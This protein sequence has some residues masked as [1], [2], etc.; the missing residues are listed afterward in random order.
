[1]AIK[2]APEEFLVEETLTAEAAAEIRPSGGRFAL[3]RLTKTGWTTPEAVYAVARALGIKPAALA[4]GGLKDKHARTLQHLSLDTAGLPGPAPESLAG[5]NWAALRLGTVRR[6]MSADSV[7]GNRFRIVIRKLSAEACARMDAAT[8]DFALPGR[9]TGLRVVNYFG[10]QRF[11]SA[12]HGQGFAA[13]HL[14]RDEWEAG[15]R[16]ILTAVARKDDR[17]LKEAK[18]AIEAGWGDWK[19]VLAA[20]PP[21]GPL[22]GPVERLARGGSYAVAFQGLPYIDQQMHVE[23]F[24]SFLWNE[25]A[26]RTVEAGCPGPLRVAEMRYGR[27]VHPPAASVTGELASLCLPLLCPE[28][29]LE[30]PWKIP[31]EQVLAAEQIG[32]KRLRLPGLRR[33]WFGGTPRRLFLETEECDLGAPSPDEHAPGRLRRTLTLWLPRAAYATVVLQALGAPGEE[34]G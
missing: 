23:A 9:P 24:Q 16:M 12:R 11:G 8:V 25:T 18:R 33:P 6:P 1:M 2:R 10:V 19:T 7:A 34:D 17:R 14:V 13:R 28:T 3:Y 4:I 5:D 26:R 27:L 31:A 29:H 21:R 22:R 15:L 30:G 32:L 20:L